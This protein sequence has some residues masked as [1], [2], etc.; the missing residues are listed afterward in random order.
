MPRLALRH[1]ATLPA[2]TTG[3]LFATLASRLA[4][5]TVATGTRG[6]T[7]TAHR[8]RSN[9]GPSAKLTRRT[10]FTGVATVT[11]AVSAA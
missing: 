11:A 7:I 6:A 9:S 5:R 1:P 3:L 10:S 8:R 2:A 4:E